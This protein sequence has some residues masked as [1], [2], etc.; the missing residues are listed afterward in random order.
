MTKLL[1]KHNHLLGLCS[2]K[3]LVINIDGEKDHLVDE[4]LD[5]ID[6]DIHAT[7]NKWDN[8]TKKINKL[9]DVKPI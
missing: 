6:S 7:P 5:S 8:L 3:N 9:D 1:K 4:E 2:H